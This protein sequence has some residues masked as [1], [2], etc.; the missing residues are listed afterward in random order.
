MTSQGNE[1]VAGKTTNKA[2]T[3]EILLPSAMFKV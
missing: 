1:A 2:Y 3:A